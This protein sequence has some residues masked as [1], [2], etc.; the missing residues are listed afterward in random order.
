MG[1]PYRR[2]KIWWIQYY[3][4][5]KKVRESSKSTKKMVAN[6][7]LARRLGDIAKGKIPGTYQERVT[8]DELAEA[9]L[10]D[11]RINQKKSLV[12]AERSVRHLK[13]FFE[14]MKAMDIITPK[15]QAYI[16]ERLDTGA[17]NASINREL[18]ALKRMLNLGA[19]QTPPLL[20][21]VP[22]VPK[23]K[24]NNVRK[25]FFE[26]DEFLK[27]REYLPGYLKGMV[28][29]A[30]KFGWRSSELTGLRW[31]QVDRREWIVSLDVGET[32]NDEGRTVYLDN[33]LKAIFNQLWE[34]RKARGVLIPYVF[35]NRLGTGKIGD[36]RFAWNKAFEE[37]GVER[38]LFH[39]FR[40]TAVRNMV[41]AG[42]PERVAMMIS[43][44]KTRSVFDRYNIVNHKDLKQAAQLQEEYLN[45][46][47]SGTGTVLGT[48]GDLTQKKTP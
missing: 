2:G 22:K 44:H 33:E 19:S 23:L 11:Y 35:P 26:I 29:F 34:E 18:A 36:F 37:S 30:Y 16:E 45:S 31:S 24:E 3:R 40:R 13:Q 8:F 38:K 42:I 12:R 47:V 15:I 46:G 17:A 10:R 43:G 48:I 14:G 20:D 4:N 1:D 32:K 21:R 25:G 7:L 6:K 27:F 41:R 5:G 39:D 28:T 9:F